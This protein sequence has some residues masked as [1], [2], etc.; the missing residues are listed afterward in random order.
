MDGHGPFDGIVVPGRGRAIGLLASDA[1][2]DQLHGLF[3]LRFVPGTLN[4]RLPAPF[5][6]RLATR[7]IAASEIRDGWEAETGQTGYVFVPV[8]VEGRH[9]G[10]AFQAEEDDYPADLL[11]ILAEV[12]LRSA[13]GLV[14][15][16]HVRLEIG[17][18]A[19]DSADRQAGS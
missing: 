1:I 13:L 3:G 5:D 18:R 19:A 16:D 2:L 10:V 8:L 12:H 11:E 15:G 7:R 17:E 14:D 6:R 4:L 9:R